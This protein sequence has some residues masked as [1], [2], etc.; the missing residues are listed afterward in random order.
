M[1][2]PLI[3]PPSWRLLCVGS[4]TSSNGHL[5]RQEVVKILS[6]LHWLKQISG[7][8]GLDALPIAVAGI[9]LHALAHLYSTLPSQYHYVYSHIFP[10]PKNIRKPEYA[11]NFFYFPP[12]ISAT[13][14]FCK[15]M[16]F[17]GRDKIFLGIFQRVPHKCLAYS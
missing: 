13:C 12:I 1:S 11:Q 5:Y 16:D 3:N 2:P 6:P 7:H 10:R 14:F 15:H 9:L 17:A 4:A 8:V